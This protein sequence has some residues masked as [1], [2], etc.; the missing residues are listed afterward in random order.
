MFPATFVRTPLSLVG[1]SKGPPSFL[2][3]L[4]VV[5]HGKQRRERE[6]FCPET[7][8]SSYS[9]GRPQVFGLVGWA[10]GVDQIWR[11]KLGRYGEKGW[12]KRIDF[13]TYTVAHH[14]VI[15]SP[16][17]KSWASIKS[18]WY[19]NKSCDSL[20]PKL[21]STRKERE[22]ER[23]RKR[24]RS[25]SQFRNFSPFVARCHGVTSKSKPIPRW[26]NRL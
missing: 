20:S 9:S 2:G 12:N 6:I 8:S 18:P 5:A 11:E 3:L 22:G 16:S 14:R 7:S 24:K 19:G 23:D 10:F 4:H 26:Q 21:L 25:L 17:F 15:I 13:F 1:A